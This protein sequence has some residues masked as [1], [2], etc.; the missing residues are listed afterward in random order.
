MKI[1]VAR[2]TVT[3]G[4]TWCNSKRSHRVS[5]VLLKESRPRVL[6]RYLLGDIDLSMGLDA[7]NRRLLAR[8]GSTSAASVLCQGRSDL[9]G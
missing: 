1:F 6:R 9:H 3:Q 5:L 2:A 7:Q 8:F 4:L